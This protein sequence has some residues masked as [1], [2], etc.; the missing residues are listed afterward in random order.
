[1]ETGMII[2]QPQAA[3]GLLLVATLLVW[4]GGEKA[5]G[6]S[7]LILSALAGAFV[8]LATLFPLVGTGQIFRQTFS[9]LPPF[10][11]SF[12]ADLFSVSLALLFLFSGFVLALYTSAYPLK[13]DERRFK[14]AFLFIMA[15]ASGVVLA[16]DLL[17]LFLFFEA[18]SLV[19]FLLIIHNRTR[20]AIAATYKFIYLTI[21]GSMCYF[22]ALA[23]VFVQ[24]DSF[25]WVQGGFMPATSLSALA[26]GGFVI[27]FG[28][29]AGMVPL[30]F[31]LAAAYGQAPP[32]A[33]VLSSVIMMKTGAYGMIRI[34]HHVFGPEMLSLHGWDKLILSFALFTIFYG[35]FC[36][37]AERDLLRRLAYSSMAQ[38]SYILFGLALL[39]QAALVGAIFHILAHGMMK[40]TM[41]LC[42]GAIVSKTGK[43]KIADLEGIGRQMPLTMACFSLAALTAVGLPPMNI[44]IVK[45]YLSLGAL[46][47]GQ[48][49]L[50]LFLLASSLLNAAYYLPIVFRAY[51]GAESSDLHD[52]LV[53]DR[54]PWPMTVAMLLFASA[55][56]VFSLGSVNLP[57]EWTKRIAAGF[58]Y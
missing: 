24:A 11:L 37:F 6:S 1:M 38:L 23:T 39:N 42:A 52:R 18:M 25:A 58:F 32:P 48:P 33:A 15:C 57:L 16:G 56:L 54:L 55:C 27:A 7:S 49:L 13:H 53:W 50:I 5:R 46:S 47:A 36:A 26:F 45:W 20:E 4:L 8:I 40:G 22:M 21:G 44:F 35:S 19:F 17:S 9:I 43:R 28:M 3:F 14:T 10:G 51:F 29:K 30:H 2:W 34:F 12:H 41:L 31:W